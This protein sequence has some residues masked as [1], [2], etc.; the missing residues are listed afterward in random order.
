MSQAAIK[1]GTSTYL[2]SCAISDLVCLLC[3]LMFRR[4]LLSTGCYV[5]PKNCIFRSLG[6]S[7]QNFPALRGF[8]PRG[9]GEADPPPWAFGPCWG[10][11]PHLLR[12]LPSETYRPG[13][14]LCMRLL[15]RKI[16]NNNNNIL[17]LAFQ[18]GATWNK[19]GREFSL[20]RGIWEYP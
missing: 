17:A 19:P 2:F 7:G 15:R 8:A 5:V 16:P 9:A 20:V 6:P 3:G 10:A 12:L 4:V 13:V 1:L 11:A 14:L 18:Q